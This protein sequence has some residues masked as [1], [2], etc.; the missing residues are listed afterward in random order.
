MSS[1]GR[2][3]KLSQDVDHDYRLVSSRTIQKSKGLIAS[4]FYCESLLAINLSYNVMPVF[5]IL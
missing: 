2:R 1:Y 3:I 4:V 5:V